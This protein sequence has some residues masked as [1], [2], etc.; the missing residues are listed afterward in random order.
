MKKT[1]FSE[2]QDCP[3]TKNG[4][5]QST[6]YGVGGKAKMPDDVETEMENRVLGRSE[7]GDGSHG[8]QRY[9]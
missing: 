9:R 7:G 3:K 8:N 6:I 1:N 2:W 5:E 4:I